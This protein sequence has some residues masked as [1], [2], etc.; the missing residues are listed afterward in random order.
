[1]TTYSRRLLATFGA[2]LAAAY[3]VISPRAEA[4]PLPEVVATIADSGG[5]YRYGGASLAGADCSGLVSIAQT[6]AMGEQP[7][8]LGNTESMLAGQWPHAIPGASPDDAFIIGV[9]ASHMVAKVGGVR[10]EATC[11][12]QPFKVGPAATSPF[13]PQ[14]QQYRIDEAVLR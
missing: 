5:H 6:L 13:A 8:R 7:H 10:I 4:M 9:N 2:L 12:G 11:C 1:M 3:L 14:F